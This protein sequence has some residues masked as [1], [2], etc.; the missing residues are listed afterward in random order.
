MATAAEAVERTQKPLQQF[1]RGWMLS[2]ATTRH[3]LELGLRSARDFRHVGRAGVLGSCPLDVAV[4]ALA[5]VSP[6]VVEQAWNHLP[7]GLTHADVTEHYVGLVL[8]WGD[9]ALTPFPAERLDRLDV[10]G[11]RV[12][13]AAPS[14]L[15][16][17]FAGWRAVPEPETVYRRVALT[18][19][20]LREMRGAAHIAAVITAGMTPVDAILA[21]T[22]SP[23]RTG[24]DYAAAKGFTG[25]FR[26][27]AEIR[28]QR[29]EVE[30]STS[31]IMEGF[32]GVLSSEELDDFGELVETTRNA[33]DM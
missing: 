15:G 11:R 32:Y 9:D 8:A 2:E 4:G 16:P 21:S 25:P 31:R 18:T 20:V 33:I 1:T 27:P 19:Q 10:L 22:N 7:A 26:D 28:E 13:N 3:G 5:F 6:E 14:S 12:V 29:L 30:A 17:L 24:P 23:P